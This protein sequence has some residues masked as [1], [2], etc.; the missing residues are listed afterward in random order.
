MVRAKA[1]RASPTRRSKLT[2]STPHLPNASSSRTSLKHDRNS[3]RCPTPSVTPCFAGAYLRSSEAELVCRN[4]LAAPEC[5]NDYHRQRLRRLAASSAGTQ[6]RHVRSLLER[7][8]MP[9]GV[10]LRDASIAVYRSTGRRRD[11]PPIGQ[12]EFLIT[13][14]FYEDIPGSKRAPVVGR[15]HASSIPALPMSETR[16]TL[17]VE[18]DQPRVRAVAVRPEV[19]IA[20]ASVP[21]QA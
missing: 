2:A 20:D 18:A 21:A 6:W 15:W 17:V 5:S 14:G 1:A 3:S 8:L 7:G 10:S 9:T 12:R 16:R 19:R 13:M 11:E 4:T